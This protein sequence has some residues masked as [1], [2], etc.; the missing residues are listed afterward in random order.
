MKS[1]DTTAQSDRTA[2]HYYQKVI[3]VSH[4]QPHQ[5]VA[6]KGGFRDLTKGYLVLWVNHA[7]ASQVVTF[8]L[9]DFARTFVPNGNLG[10]DH[11]WGSH[12]IVMGGAV[13]GS[14]F[15][16]V[17]G[18]NGTV[19][20]TLAPAGPDDTNEDSGARGRSIQWLQSTSTARP[21]PPGLALGTQ[22]LPQACRIL[23][24]SARPRLGS[25]VRVR[26]GP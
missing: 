15:Y 25:W 19:F 10:T 18:S 4:M 22:I 8:T 13:R 6:K 5:F 12:H 3:V 16:G 14:D 7:V 23:G 24:D 2:R 9:S 26:Q 11:A 1:D 21:S 17:P 20:P